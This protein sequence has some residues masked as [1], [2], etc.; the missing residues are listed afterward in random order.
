MIT[1]QELMIMHMIAV[2]PMFTT[3]LRQDQITSFYNLTRIFMHALMG[4]MD[5]M[6]ADSPEHKLAQEYLDT[7]RLMIEEHLRKETT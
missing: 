7:T 4:V 1:S 5:V 2:S 6:P 3:E